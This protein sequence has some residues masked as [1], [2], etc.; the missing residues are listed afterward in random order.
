MHITTLV[1]VLYH[2]SLPQY[3]AFQP[4]AQTSNQIR[5]VLPQQHLRGINQAFDGL[6]GE[7]TTTNFEGVINR[8]LIFGLGNIGTLLAESS[9]R[10]TI[11][12]NENNVR[13]DRDVY[14]P[15]Y[16]D[17]I[18]GT[19]RDEKTIDGVQVLNMS[20]C[21]EWKHILPTCTHILVTVPPIDSHFNSK[22][23]IY[24]GG[25]PRKWTYF[26]DS[27]LN[28]PHVSLREMIPKSTWIGY[29]STTSVYGNHDGEWVTEDSELKCQP[30]SKGELYLKA[31]EEWR[32]AARECGW[33]LHIFRCA[34][35]Y[36]NGR[37]ALHTL[38][39][40][41]FEPRMGDD[42]AGAVKRVEYPTSRIHEEDV[43]WAILRAMLHHDH[44]AVGQGCIWNLAD[45]DPAPRSEVMFYGSKL[46]DETGI[47]PFPD[48][49]L[50][51]VNSIVGEQQESQREKRRKL[52]RKRVC[53]LRMKT[54]LL[55][56]G[57]LIYPT[58]REGLKS[59]L[60]NNKDAWLL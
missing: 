11:H 31:E 59:I 29:I 42:G 52:D 36:G 13:N 3:N 21:Q 57:R 30:G 19:T 28:H 38:M 40:C 48:R 60:R 50:T 17:H 6:H 32:K 35:L 37:S 23:Q 12:D 2:L 15:S 24:V 22:Q 34:G 18:Y 27:I 44:S 58:Y 49:A 25:R 46:L 7:E 33:K 1:V 5:T 43:V 55:P 51:P 39:K 14:T 47:A 10:C 4:P 20:S 54:G 26:C 41:G 45:D 53:N 56:D 8:L 9:S 16:F